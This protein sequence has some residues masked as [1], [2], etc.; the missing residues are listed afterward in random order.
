MKFQESVISFQIKGI[1]KQQVWKIYNNLPEYGLDIQAAFVN[2]CARTKIYTPENF[3]AY[4]KSK[5]EGDTDF[6]ALTEDEYLF[7]S[8]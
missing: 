1:R 5:M 8:K 4:L 7:H 2:W 3:V 6:I